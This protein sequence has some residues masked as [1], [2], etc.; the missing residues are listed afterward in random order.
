M[1]EHSEKL[2]HHFVLNTALNF[3]HFLLIEMNS[4]IVANKSSSPVL[5]VE[6]SFQ[7]PVVMK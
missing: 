2:I 3:V 6:Q 1:L 5:D 7:Q 4:F